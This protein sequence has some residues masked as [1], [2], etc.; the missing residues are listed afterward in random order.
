MDKRPPNTQ[1]AC[2]GY[3]TWFDV[4]NK[5]QEA[6]QERLWPV[7]YSHSVVW[8]IP[9]LRATGKTHFLE[10]PSEIIIEGTLALK[11]VPSP[12]TSR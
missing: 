12:S 2:Q 5:S 11:H 10:A 9:E 4:G 3:T 8:L 7:T 1:C 6:K